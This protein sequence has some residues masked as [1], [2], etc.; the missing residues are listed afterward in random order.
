M[1]ASAIP[2]CTPIQISERLRPASRGL[3]MAQANGI[4]SRLRRKTAPPGPTR[5]NSPTAIAAP[6]W[7]DAAASRTRPSDERCRSV[8]DAELLGQAAE[9]AVAVLGHHDQVLDPHTDLAGQINPWLDGDRL[10]GEKGVLGASRQARR[11]V[12]LEPD[13]V[14]EAV[15]E[16]LAVAGLGDQ[17]ACDRVDGLA[18]LAGCNGFEGLA[19]CVEDELVDGLAQ[20]ADFAARGEGAGAVG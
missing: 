19:L 12:H 8:D 9:I 5:S 11:L 17:I 3:A 16:A 10:A 1:T 4:A 18:L 2:N 15:A 14:A 13:A 7:I 20:L 6:V